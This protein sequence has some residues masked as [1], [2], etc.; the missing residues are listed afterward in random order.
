M[1][2]TENQVEPALD[3]SIIFERLPRGDRGSTLPSP[4]LSVALQQVE[5]RRGLDV[6]KAPG[7]ASKRQGGEPA[8]EIE[9]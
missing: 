4:A 8:I 9:S 2:S 3:V 5:Q 7:T 1:S 6:V